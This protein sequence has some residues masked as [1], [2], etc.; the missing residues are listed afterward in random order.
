MRAVSEKMDKYFCSHCLQLW[1]QDK[2][3]EGCKGCNGHIKKGWSTK[4]LVEIY[5]P[6]LIA[7]EVDRA[8]FP[9]LHYMYKPRLMSN[10]KYTVP[11]EQLTKMMS[12]TDYLIGF[13]KQQILFYRKY[14]LDQ[15]DRNWNSLHFL[16]QRMAVP[17]IK[18]YYKS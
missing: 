3:M 8:Y 14:K 2:I 13:K 10:P 9:F 17:Q 11:I 18:T 5:E 12:N 4:Q 7:S 15:T 6:I 16:V 1:K